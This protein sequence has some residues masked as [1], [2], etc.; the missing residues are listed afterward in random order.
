M[1]YAPGL[2]KFIPPNFKVKCRI[3]YTDCPS[4]DRI[5]WKV[6][7]VG[8]VA[9]RKNCIRGQIKEKGQEIIEPTSF[10]GTHFIECYLIKDEVCV[11]IGHI[12]VPIGEI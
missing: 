3:N 5:F 4:Y 9:E 8:E 10:R 2:E 11:A 12:T 7:N 6:R 1:Q